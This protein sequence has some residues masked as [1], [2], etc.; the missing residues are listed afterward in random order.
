MLVKI[1]QIKNFLRNKNKKNDRQQNEFTCM[2]NTG[3]YFIMAHILIHCIWITLIMAM[4]YGGLEVVVI[5]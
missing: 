5:I 4:L 2:W 3:L 1:Y